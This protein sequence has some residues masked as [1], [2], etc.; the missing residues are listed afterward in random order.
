MTH[1]AP[2]SSSAEVAVADFFASHTPIDVKA[3]DADR[4]LLSTGVLDSLH[5]IELV[6]W[7]EGRTGKPVAVD[8]LLPDQ[9]LSFRAICDYLRRE[10]ATGGDCAASGSADEPLRE[11][12]P[13]HPANMSL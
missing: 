4:L 7:L 8:E 13:G 12:P 9:D 5:L 11:T 3:L 10:T 6:L 2:L 1:Q